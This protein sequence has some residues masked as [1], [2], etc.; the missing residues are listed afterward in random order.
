MT[1]LRIIIQSLTICLLLAAASSFAQAQTRTWVSGT[2]SDANPCSRSAPCLTFAGAISKTSAGGEISVLD[3]HSYGPVTITKS[4]TINGEGSLASIL[5]GLNGTGITV[6]AG[7]SDTVYIKNI[8]IN[9][10]GN[11]SNGITWIAGNALILDKVRIY[12]FT[13]LGLNVN[14]SASGFLSMTNSAITN[15]VAGGLQATTNSGVL[16]GEIENTKIFGCTNGVKAVVNTQLT[17]KN[18]TVSGCGT[19]GFLATGPSAVLNLQSCTATN[20]VS[21]VKTELG[22]LVRLGQSTVANNITKGLDT[23]AGGTIESYQDNYISG[24]P[25]SDAS[26]PINPS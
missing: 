11:G 24:N 5:V 10:A 4:I 9:G 14:K 6:N 12:T 23:A 18:S 19:A 13:N 20:N 16:R 26:S 1:K 8:D 21:G 15:C 22:G 3:P 7:A 2:G 17:F 25:N